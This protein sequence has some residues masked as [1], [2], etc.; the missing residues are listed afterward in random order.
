M[1]F[2]SYGAKIVLSGENQSLS[3]MV[4]DFWLGMATFPI[5]PA[6]AGMTGSGGIQAWEMLS[7]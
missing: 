2:G 3:P 4:R 5:I 7:A 6:C 1:I